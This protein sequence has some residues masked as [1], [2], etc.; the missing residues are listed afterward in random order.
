MAAN[1]HG[2]SRHI[3]AAVAREIRRRSRFGCVI[4]RSGFYQYEHI[5]PEFEDATVHDPA[6]ICCL[7]GSCHDAVTRGQ[8][9]KAS[10]GA[11][12]RTIQSTPLA[13]VS[14]PVGPIDF[15]GGNAI[16]SIGGLR[17][18]PAVQ[19]V[20]KNYGQNVISVIPGQ[21]DTP[22]T[23]SAIFTDEFGIP[24]LKLVE[25]AWEGSTLNWDIE[26]VGPCITVRRAAGAV[27]LK[28]RL[29]PPGVVV[30]EHLDMRLGEFHLLISENSYAVGRYSPNEDAIAWL[31]AELTI[32]RSAGSGSAIEFTDPYELL[33]RIQTIGEREQRMESADH[34]IIF[35]SKYGCLWIP[36]G[37]AIASDCGGFKLYGFAAGVR[38]I[39]GVR[40]MVRQAPSVLM[41]YLGTGKET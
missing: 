13:E 7:C 21:G 40:R 31:H 9:S 25:N 14:K 4:C 24:V 33:A 27:A 3:P 10:V 38:P 19:T 29:D 26:V 12:Y 36:A 18:S 28:L 30:V 39:D 8:R 41:R 20:L 2:L 35:S 11:A 6:H 15:Y 5:D 32:T 22:G 34:S 16:L 17:Y 1:K 37:I 23:I